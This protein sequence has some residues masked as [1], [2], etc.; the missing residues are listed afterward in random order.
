ETINPQKT[1]FKGFGSAILTLVGLCV[2]TF[3]SAVGVAGWE[4]VVYTADGQTSDSPLPLALG[5]IVSNNNM[6]YH[7][8]VTVGLLGLVASFHGLILAAGRASFEMGRVG[9]APAF[10]G[11]IA[12]RFHTPAWAL[13]VN[14]LAGI[15]TLYLGDT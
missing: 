10:L 11:K 4:A 3:I 1:I 13:L 6:L 15:I 9:L 2:L 14:M 12:P 7:L 8:L 5:H